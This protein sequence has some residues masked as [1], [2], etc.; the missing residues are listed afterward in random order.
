MASAIRMGSFAPAMA[1]FIRT[2]SAPYSIAR[3][4]SEAVPTP[5]STMTG[6]FTDSMRIFRLYGLRI[7]RPEPIGAASGITADRLGSG[8]PQPV[9]PENPHGVRERAG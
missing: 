6:T 8:D 5:A 1:V 4:A 3:A 7:P 9:Q 2:A